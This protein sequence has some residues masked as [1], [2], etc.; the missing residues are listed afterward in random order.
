VDVLVATDVAARGI[1]V[2]DVTH[3]VNYQCPED[4]KTYVHRIGRTGRAGHTGTAITFVDWDDV[5]RWLLI[6]RALD[7]G[8]GEPAETYS[9]SPHVYSDLDIAENAT[10][11]LPRSQRTRAG[12]SAEEVE[13]LGETGG[14]GKSSGRSRSG[15]SG[16]GG[17]GGRGSGRSGSGRGR[18]RGNGGQGQ[19]AS[20]E[21]GGSSASGSGGGQSGRRRRRRRRTRGGQ[22]AQQP[23]SI[24]GPSNAG[25]VN[26]RGSGAN[27]S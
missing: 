5:P 9:S 2:D 8:I 19:N 27:G 25:P 17:S 3:V 15:S 11:R 22:P 13:D 4:E 14:R 10:G 20:R 6:D 7:L 18:S 23:S 24:A 1:D 16:R 26:A 12:L 21:H